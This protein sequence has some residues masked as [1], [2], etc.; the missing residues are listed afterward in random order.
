MGFFD[1]RALKKYMKEADK[2]AKQRKQI[3]KY[4]AL[5]KQI[6]LSKTKVLLVDD[7]YTTGSTMRATIN[8]VER[9]NP[10]DIKVLVLA[11]TSD[12]GFKKVT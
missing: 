1:K 8:M 5:K 7:I 11:K 6:D 10:K 4:L 2:N 9:L 3:N 12:K